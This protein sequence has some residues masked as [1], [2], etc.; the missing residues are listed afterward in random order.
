MDSQLD[1]DSVAKH[2]LI[3]KPQK[4]VMRESS[5]KNDAR[6]S[7][8]HRVFSFLPDPCTDNSEAETKQRA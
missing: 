3:T 5:T 1:L 7:L 6:R 8:S 4:D 2:N